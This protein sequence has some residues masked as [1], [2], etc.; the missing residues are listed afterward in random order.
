[1]TIMAGRLRHQITIQKLGE[2]VTQNPYGEEDRAWHNVLE[3]WAEIDPPKGREFFAAGQKQAE[4]TTRIR[5]RYPTGIDITVAM[6]I[7]KGGSTSRVFEINS[8]ID[9]DERNRELIMMCT[10]EV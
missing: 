5:I 9:P 2:P 3:T 8:V 6:R 1:M 10:E 4:V 7:L